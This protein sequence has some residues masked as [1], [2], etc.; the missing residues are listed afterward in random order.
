MPKVKLATKFAKC[1]TNEDK[2]KFIIKQLESDNLG[3]DCIWEG[4]N[5]KYT[6]GPGWDSI[7]VDKKLFTKIKPKLKRVSERETYTVHYFWVLKDGKYANY[8]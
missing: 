7:V 8:F 3:Y 1:K 4:Y 5:K 6:M 2:V